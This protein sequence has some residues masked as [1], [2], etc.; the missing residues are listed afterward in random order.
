[1]QVLRYFTL[2]TEAVFEGL[3]F[4]EYP[5]EI[6]HV[7]GAVAFRS[8]HV[9]VPKGWSLLAAEILARKYC[10]RNVVPRI[11]KPVPEEGVPAW[12]WRNIP[13]T[14]ALAALPE[15]ERFLS[16]TD[17]RQV[18]GRMAGFW[19]YWGWK[20]GYFDSE[21][22]A[23][24]FHAECCHMLASQ[25]FAPNSP[26]WF[27][28]GL[29]WAY[30]VDQAAEGYFHVDPATGKAQA[31]TSAYERS[32]V[33]SCFIQ[34]VGDS[35]VADGGIVDL[36]AV[37]AKI[38]KF[39]A[40]TGANFSAIRAA[41]EKLSAGGHASGLLTALKASDRAAPLVSAK[42]STRQAS[43]MVLVDADHPEI[44]DYIEWKVEEERKVAAIVA[45]SLVCDEHLA[46]IYDAACGIP[47]DMPLKQ[48]MSAFRD[49]RV[50]V[51]S[52]RTHGVP[53]NAILSTIAE[54]RLGE[55]RTAQ[56]RFDAHWDS[57]G[58]R[59]VSGQNS[60]NSIRVTNRFLAA[61]DADE[62]WDLVERTTGKVVRKVRARGLFDRMA[63]AAWASA[64]PGLQY[65][66]TINEWH[67]CPAEGAINASNSC[68][69]YL[70]LDDTGTTLASLN[71][72][73]FSRDGAFDI[74][75]FEHVVRLVTL[76]TEI[77]VSA[78]L[79]PSERIAERTHAYR[80]LGLGFT[81]LGGMLM[82][83][84]IAYDSDAGRETCAAL[85]ALLAG[86]T[87][88]A[89]A[90]IAAD[91]G[92]FA[93]FAPN[94]EAMLRVI[95]NH[96]RAAYGEVSGYEG[97][98]TLPVPLTGS[99][100]ADPALVSAAR[101]AF[102]R[103]LTLGER[104]GYR[105]A[106]ATSI[107]PTGTIS[108]VMDCDSMGIEP[109]FALVK[110]KTLA[111]GGHL[112]IINR[113]VPEALRALGYGAGEIEAI[114]RYVTGYRTLADAPAINHQTLRQRGFDDTL[115]ASME[116]ALAK[117]PNLRQAMAPD[118][119]GP[120]LLAGQFGLSD[121]DMAQDGFDLLGR[122]G[123]APSEIEAADAH[124]FGHLTLEGAPGLN[125]RHLP[126][127]DCSVP[128]G[129]FGVRSLSAESHLKMMA[130]AQPFVSGAIS[131]TVNL[132]GQASVN[133]CR[134]VLREGKAL[135]LKAIALYRDGSKLS[136]PLMSANSLPS[137]HLGATGP[138]E[139]T[140]TSA[141][142]AWQAE[143]IVGEWA[144]LARERGPEGEATRHPHLAPVRAVGTGESDTPALPASGIGP[145][146]TVAPDMLDAL[147]SSVQLALT[148]GAPVGQVR[149]ALLQ[150]MIEA[151][152]QR[153]AARL[154][155][156]VN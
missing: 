97:L 57:E 150:P 55:P 45:G 48:A 31:A 51:T 77:S 101:R 121:A 135:G 18:F 29:H 50:A 80:P 100:G 3:Q 156:R 151:R 5:I 36:I 13:D 64:D 28:T 4:V 2:E 49:L 78:S 86:C 27:N 60:N 63:R 89:S 46:S 128:C 104:N 148:H 37:E 44:E 111:G 11:L 105:N 119:L 15:A 43:K 117:A 115:I 52:A 82:A 110:H 154:Q 56:R 54:A 12:L 125:P 126:V 14:E 39:G 23:V 22:D 73:S 21:A 9:T 35:L 65:A 40:G 62:D 88:A 155:S 144:A 141:L 103:A 68:S 132:S 142:L 138:T 79:Y 25:R 16:E 84:G 96:R 6:R 72:R 58:Y 109:D 136:Q 129:A 71:L 70:F 90:E 120:A 112:N 143:R 8:D 123:F 145:A 20:G 81:N 131:K 146:S 47:P 149:D 7:G 124:Y 19:T 42:G 24:A 108:L 91:V 127:F 106:Q 53:D 102:D 94:R 99:A 118:H 30:G 69:E 113:A 139:A 134:D 153:D 1:M 76:A 93:G 66:D 85:S 74:P 26:Q 33:H 92:P 107:A 114:A 98:S 140:R 147:I 95:R 38:A 83:S 17:A 133:D 41:S 32:F 10:R 61:V 75:A 34:S 116:R 59:S 67:T 152:Q 87:Y 137:D 130:A 122:L